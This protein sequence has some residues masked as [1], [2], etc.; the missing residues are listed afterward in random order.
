MDS[1]AVRE[2]LL[3]RGIEA[4]EI[5]RI[6][7]GWASHTFEVDGEWIFRFP[8]NDEIARSLEREI[9]LL[10]SLARAVSFA[11]PRFEF[12]G[13]YDDRLYAGY[14][15]IEGV[16]LDEI[17]LD[18]RLIEGVA[19]ALRELHDFPASDARDVFGDPGTVDAW[20]DDYIRLREKAEI[21]VRPLLD[22]A[23]WNA[24][25]IGFEQFLTDLDFSPA[26]VHR[27]LG[28]EHILVDRES[29]SVTGIIDFEE[30]GVGD[31][32]I[33]FVGLQIEFGDELVE[34]IAQEYGSAFDGAARERCKFYAWMGSVHAIFYGLE[35]SRQSIVDDGVRVLPKRLGV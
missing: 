12:I 34:R 18:D 13:Y 24:V 33:D 5:V 30:A 10:P 25:T 26:L 23:T 2:L 1:D 28:M 20:R 16:A 22:A 32:V 19:R 21:Q 35:T 27:D 29:M 17:E 6:E 8:R 3:P 31:P 15:K 9:R 4:R 14:R 11:V 7:G